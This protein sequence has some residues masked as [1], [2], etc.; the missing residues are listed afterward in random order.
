M[1]ADIFPG[2]GKIFRGAREDC[3]LK[4]TFYLKTPKKILSYYFWPGGLFPS[5]R[6]AQEYYSNFILVL[7]TPQN[8]MFERQITFAL[9][10]IEEVAKKTFY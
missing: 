1:S 10:F 6:D 9:K 5:S 3:G 4:R 2:Q 8:F 7:K